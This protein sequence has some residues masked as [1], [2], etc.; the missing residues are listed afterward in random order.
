MY[1]YF[2]F[3]RYGK[4]KGTNKDENKAVA[5]EGKLHETTQINGMM[6]IQKTFRQ[7][8][9]CRGG[10]SLTVLIMADKDQFSANTN[11]IVDV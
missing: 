9:T 6:Y 1:P 2:R 11:M 3:S 5:L 4:I 10:T 7:T 8:L